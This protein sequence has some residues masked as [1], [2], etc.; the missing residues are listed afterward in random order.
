MTPRDDNDETTSNTISN[1]H[2]HKIKVASKLTASVARC[3]GGEGDKND[4][5]KN[6]NKNKA[7]DHHFAQADQDILCETIV[8]CIDVNGPDCAVVLNASGPVDEDVHQTSSR[9]HQESINSISVCS[10]GQDDGT[11]ACSGDANFAKYNDVGQDDDISDKAEH[12]HPSQ[13]QLYKE[14]DHNTKSS[15]SNSSQ[16]QSNK[17]A[18]F[19][20][21]DKHDLLYRSATCVFDIRAFLCKHI[22]YHAEYSCLNKQNSKLHKQSMLENLLQN[23]NCTWEQLCTCFTSRTVEQHF[24]EIN[25]NSLNFIHQ[26]N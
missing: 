18:M 6:N 9:D 24:H 16:S 15:F 3:Q 22:S 23:T 2:S 11:K 21:T 20:N 8:S 5:E 14:S 17:N 7:D 19:S 10:V 4:N 25:Q 26:D 1:N 12:E 13:A